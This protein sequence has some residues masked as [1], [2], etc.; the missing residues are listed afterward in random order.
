MSLFVQP[1]APTGQTQ[2]KAAPS[3]PDPIPASDRCP[4]HNK[5]LFRLQDVDGN[6]G[7]VRGGYCGCVYELD[8][9]KRLIGV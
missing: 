4:T 8:S 1:P 5:P 6:L 7:F 9:F 3:L 2:L